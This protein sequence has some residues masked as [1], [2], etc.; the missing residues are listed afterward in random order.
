MTTMTMPRI[1]SACAGPMPAQSSHVRHAPHNAS[2]LKQVDIGQPPGGYS[3]SAPLPGEHFRGM[4]PGGGGDLEPAQHAC[5]L[6]HPRVCIEGGDI[7]RDETTVCLF[8]HA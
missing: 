3:A 2:V 8:G 5:D 1:V 7:G 6:L 4:L